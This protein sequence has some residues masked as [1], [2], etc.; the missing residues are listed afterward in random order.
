[1]SLIKIDNDSFYCIEEIKLGEVIYFLYYDIF[2]SHLLSGPFVHSDFRNGS[3]NILN[4]TDF[5]N[6]LAEGGIFI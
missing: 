2:H 5:F 3:L 1:M 4:K 6:I